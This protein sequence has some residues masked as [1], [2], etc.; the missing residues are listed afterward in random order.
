[1]WALK[2]MRSTIAATR[3]VGEHRSPLAERKIAR[4]PDTGSFLSLCDDLAQQFGSAKVY[5]NGLFGT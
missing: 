4:Q 2:V 5:R 1:M 3:R